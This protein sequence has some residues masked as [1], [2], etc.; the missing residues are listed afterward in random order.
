MA[1]PV[2]ATTPTSTSGSGNRFHT[3]RVTTTTGGHERIVLLLKLSGW[4]E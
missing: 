2:R 4:Y 1:S 3:T